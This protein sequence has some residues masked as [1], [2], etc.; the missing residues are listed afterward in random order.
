MIAVND[1][2][3]SSLQLNDGI[4]LEPGLIKEFRLFVVCDTPRVMTYNLPS[5]G[6]RKQSILDELACCH[7]GM[8]Y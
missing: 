6:H 2:L 4:Y 5:R 3:K 7:V 1:R 8:E